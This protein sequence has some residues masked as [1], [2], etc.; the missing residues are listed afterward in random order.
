MNSI[1]AKE[2]H[3]IL[4]HD[5]VEILDVRTTEEFSTGHIPGA[6]NIDINNFQFADQIKK[7]ATEKQYVVNCLSGGRSLRACSMMSDLGFKKVFNL[8]GG[9]GSWKMEGFPIER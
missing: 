4:A 3:E 6:V 2:A 5:A 1:S 8:E 7:L 9:I